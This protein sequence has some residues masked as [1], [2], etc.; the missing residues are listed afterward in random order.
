MLLHV[1]TRGSI[2]TTA[3][4]HRA[5]F[6]KK[7]YIIGLFPQKSIAIFFLQ[8]SIATRGS[9]RT[10]AFP[11]RALSAREHYITGLFPQ[12]CPPMQGSF[13]KELFNIGLFP[14]IVLQ[15]RA[16]PAKSSI[17]RALSLNCNENP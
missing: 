17:S 15:N 8:R 2:R 1:A 11:H 9:I 7:H 6:T 13:T 3:F 4:P 14:H 16:L 12:K 5:L 10:T